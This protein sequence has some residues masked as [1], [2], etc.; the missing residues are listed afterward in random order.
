[1]NP[2]DLSTWLENL[3]KA[4]TLIRETRTELEIANESLCD[5]WNNLPLTQQQS[6]KGEELDAKISATSEAIDLLIDTTNALNAAINCFY[7]LQT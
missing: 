2:S 4:K 6:D 5:N 1:M 3:K 7:E